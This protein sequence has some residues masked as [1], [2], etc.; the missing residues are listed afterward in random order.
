MRTK[1]IYNFLTNSICRSVKNIRLSKQARFISILLC[2]N[3]EKSN[4]N[5][6]DAETAFKKIACQPI[7]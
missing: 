3:C 4:K 2:A 1:S 7:I 6:F 5:F